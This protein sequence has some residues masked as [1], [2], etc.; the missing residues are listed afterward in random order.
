M[1]RLR[2]LVHGTLLVL[3]IGWVFYIGQA[4]IVPAV[5]GA[6]IVYVIVGLSQVLARLPRLGP[7]L[8]LQLRNLVSVL[9]IG[10][11][12]LLLA[13]LITSNKERAVAL[14]PQFQQ[15]LLA[16][17][18]QVAVYFGIET[19]PTWAPVLLNYPSARNE[20]CACCANA[21]ISPAR[22]RSSRPT[23]AVLQLPSRIQTTFG[24][25]PRR[26]LRRWK[27][28]SLV[29]RMKSSVPARSQM[30]RSLAPPSPSATTCVESG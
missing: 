13:Y 11:A 12:F 6:V 28:S 25:G 5:L 23:S 19:E 15:S 4:I 3:I 24:G 27:S 10:L 2:A 18:Q 26:T 29:T 7:L 8:P 20:T 21:C 14:A 16:S 30:A 22:K 17:I 9:V 1:E